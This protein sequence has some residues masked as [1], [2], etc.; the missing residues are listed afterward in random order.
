[1]NSLD[2][3]AAEN[4]ANRPSAVDAEEAPFVWN[5]LERLDAEIGEVNARSGH[6]VPHRAREE[7]LARPAGRGDA[8][9]DVYRNPGQL[10]IDSL[11]FTGVQPGADLDA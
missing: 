11:A 2:W 9:G 1:M 7:H 3:P 10:P 4:C 8:G 5:A 6:E